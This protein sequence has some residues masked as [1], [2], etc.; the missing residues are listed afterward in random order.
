MFGA[1]YFR[2]FQF[3]W[4]MTEMVWCYASEWVWRKI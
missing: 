3:G 2:M 1:E 4:F